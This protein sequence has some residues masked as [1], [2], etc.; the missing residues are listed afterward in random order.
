MLKVPTHA[1]EI[2]YL[3][4]ILEQDHQGMMFLE[5]ISY[6]IKESFVKRKSVLS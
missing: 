3:N 6:S 5:A 1:C 4:L 2:S